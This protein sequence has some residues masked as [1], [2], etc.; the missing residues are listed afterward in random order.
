MGQKY[1]EQ[2]GCVAILFPLL[3]WYYIS[4]FYQNMYLNMGQ[5]LSITCYHSDKT[6]VQIL[7]TTWWLGV[8]LG[9]PIFFCAKA[10]DWSNFKMFY[11]IWVMQCCWTY[12]PMS[13]I[14]WNTP[15]LNLAGCFPFIHPCHFLYLA[16]FMPQYRVLPS[17]GQNLPW[18]LISCR[19]FQRN[20]ASFV[21]QACSFASLMGYYV[22]ICPYKTALNTANWGLYANSF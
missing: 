1:F 15:F 3:S 2:I 6:D 10:C 22:P 8:S 16:N 11:F 7:K 17:L 20:L 4:L 14:M 13:L 21:D 18:S 9:G 12:D 5:N 19:G